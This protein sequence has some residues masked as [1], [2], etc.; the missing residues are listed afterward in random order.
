MEIELSSLDMCRH[1][2]KEVLFFFGEI[3]TIFRDD[4]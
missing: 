1:L 3:Q 4:Q 2:S